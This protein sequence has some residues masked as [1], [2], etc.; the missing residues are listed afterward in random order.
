VEGRRDFLGRTEQLAVLDRALRSADQGR[1]QLVLVTGE[2]GMGKSRL[3]EHWLERARPPSTLRVRADPDDRRVELA[4]VDQLLG[5]SPTARTAR[6]PGAGDDGGGEGEGPRSL[7]DVGL[8]LL[9]A[10][11]DTQRAGGAG[12]VF[13]DDL[14]CADD[15]SLTVLG[16]AARRLQHDRVLVVC[17]ARDHELPASAAGLTRLAAAPTGTHLRVEGLTVGQTGDLA[18]AATGR[19]L[20][21]VTVRALHDATRGNPLWVLSVAGQVSAQGI[22]PG[23]RLPTSSTLTAAL[24]E[25]VQRCPRPA[26]DLL[27]GL[28]VLAGEQPVA[29]VAAL[30][31]VDDVWS[32]LDGAVASGLVA[33]T[34]A[35]PQVT[36]AFTHPVMAPSIEE[37][38]AF[39][40]RHALHRAAAATAT[41]PGEE[42]RH[43]VACAAG[44]DPD[45]AARVLGHGRGLVTGG[46]LLEA[47]GWIH[48]AAVL[49]EDPSARD[50][51]LLEAAH[52][53]MVGGFQGPALASLQEGPCPPSGYRAL[54]TASLAWLR[55]DHEQARVGARE[56]FESQDV[57]ARA[58]AALLMA[59][60]ELVGENAVEAARWAELA[61]RVGG[62]LEREEARAAWGAAL[63]LQGD[64]EATLRLFGRPTDHPEPHR[65]TQEAMRGLALTHLDRPVEARAALTSAAAAARRHS[66][67]YLSGV[68]L[69]NLGML[70]NRC[71]NWAEATLHLERAVAHTETLEESWSS[72]VIHALAAFAPAMRGERALAGDQLA[73]ALA[74][75]PRGGPSGQV[76][77]HVAAVQVHH[78]GGDDELVDDAGAWLAQRPPSS[79]TWMPGAFQ[80]LARYVEVLVRG[81]DLERARELC[82]T[83]EA[84]AARTGRQST[85]AEARHA[86]GAI[87]AADGRCDEAEVDLSLAAEVYARCGMR[88]DA[89]LASLRAGTQQRLRGDAERAVPRLTRAMAALQQLG[90]DAY[91]PEARAELDACTPTRADRR[92]RPGASTRGGGPGSRGSLTSQEAV[93]AR[94]VADGMSN[95]EVAAE[96]LLSVR[97]VEF[98]LA[99]IFRKLGIRSRT[100]LVAHQLRATQPEP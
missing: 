94:L 77:A 1:S 26:R 59:Q 54:L 23:T 19:R 63:L 88:F 96:M 72:A 25:Q 6:A 32:A 12:V 69:A 91:V 15:A 13:V 58:G 48:H 47:S 3:V 33:C 97:T 22:S 61:T 16:F 87:A 18:L 36:V 7:F 53:A 71:G 46:A 51:L 40:R 21:P 35:P 28:A 79:G 82:G 92:A 73:R 64:P 93:V 78:A 60:L 56:A 66:V 57:R 100:Q 65:I 37:S 4:T 81:G 98:H 74:A 30:T 24:D 11:E 17:T 85:L 2:A 10:F 76:Y 70:E 41:S 62:P 29:R 67:Y 44:P 86:R 49:T 89:A 9:D 68:T 34:G 8:S 39:A 38:L 52:T 43:L 55:G 83:L 99:S 80:W 50:A 5:R 75:C 31:G 14:H 42:L 84:I 20:D 90:A 27:E 45:L 95:R